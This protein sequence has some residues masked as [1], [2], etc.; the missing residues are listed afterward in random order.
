MDN[1]GGNDM[2]LTQML[3]FKT[4]A[5]CENMTKA[6]EKLH[7]SQPALSAAIKK[8]EQEFDATLFIRSNK[9]MVLNDNG[10]LLLSHAER[11]LQDVRLMKAEMSEF[12]RRKNMIRAA[13]CDPGPK[14]YCTP[15]FSIANG[16]IELKSDD[17]DYKTTNETD[18]LLSKKYDL[19]I[20]AKKICHPDVVSA[21]FL[22]DKILLSVP[23]NSPYAKL[24]SINV[25]KATPAQILIYDVGGEFLERQYALWN[26][27]KG[28]TSLELIGEYFV[29]FQKL[30]NTDEIS[31]STLLVTNYR[32]DQVGRR[33]LI[34]TTDP[35]LEI[36]Y[37]VSYLKQN[38]SHVS[39]FLEWAENFCSL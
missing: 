35:E 37:Y 7:I 20:S 39:A 10:K 11:I 25:R 14:W 28:K 36:R 19:V 24:S 5:E 31:Q 29:Y 18:L 12:T 17:Y 13:F 38:Q 22:K 27:L 15:L 6:A 3:Q 33:V 2:E 34:P 21:I 16:G 9:K 8:L 32:D 1:E 4:I 23:Q 26:D 30:K